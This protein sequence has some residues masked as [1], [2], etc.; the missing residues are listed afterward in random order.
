VF[1]ACGVVGSV[2]IGILVDRA[3]SGRV[4]RAS[5][6]PS[7]LGALAF[8]GW[9]AL[10]LIE[11]RH[12]QIYS[13]GHILAIALIGMLI[14]APDRVLGSTAAKVLCE[15]A[16]V[17]DASVGASISGFINGCG[18]LGS[19]AQGATGAIVEAGGW[20]SLFVVLG[21]TCVLAFLAVLP[22]VR[23]ESKALSMLHEKMKKHM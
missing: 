4:L 21:V 2:L 6:A 1:D 5:L 11:Q 3:Y 13:A 10:C 8:F 16:G 15:Y 18:A 17:T 23:V 19:I 7:L 14:A 9:A 12:H 22:A 20:V